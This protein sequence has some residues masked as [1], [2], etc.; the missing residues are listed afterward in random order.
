MAVRVIEAGLKGQQSIRGITAAKAM[1]RL[2]L[3]LVESHGTGQ[4]GA[5][6]RRGSLGQR[7]EEGG[8]R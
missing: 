2:L 1:Y 6:S 5:Q 3:P 7:G 4:G 8:E